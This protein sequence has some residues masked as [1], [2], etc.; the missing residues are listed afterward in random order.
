MKIFFRLFI[1]VGLL[2]T[3][4]SGYQWF[5]SE[6]L[7]TNVQAEFEKHISL[8]RNSLSPSQIRIENDFL[9]SLNQTT[10]E[11][12]KNVE[13]YKPATIYPIPVLALAWVL[14]NWIIFGRVSLLQ[15]IPLP[16]RTALNE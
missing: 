15:I 7:L 5:R 6:R 2:T 14:I 10:A 16:K 8:P 3:I 12:L 4:G 9:N 11:E 1:V 13:V